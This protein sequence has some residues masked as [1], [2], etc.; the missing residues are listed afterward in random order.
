MTLQS[1]SY[2]VIIN[3][4]HSCRCDEIQIRMFVFLCISTEIKID[5][6][7]NNNNKMKYFLI[8]KNVCTKKLKI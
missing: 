5:R 4:H 8:S 2:I 7:N 3:N 1:Y 6:I